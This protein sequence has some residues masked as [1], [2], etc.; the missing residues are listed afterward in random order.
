VAVVN[1]VNEQL[2]TSKKCPPTWQKA[3]LTAL[4]DGGNVRLACTAAQVGRTTVYERRAADAGFAAAWDV[5]LEA[6]A[7]LLEAEARRRAHDG[8]DEPVFGNLGAGRGSGEVGTV[9][10]YSDTL[11]IFLLKGARPEKYRERSDVKVSGEIA[12]V[13]AGFDPDNI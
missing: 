7:D 1:V 8:W 13:Y 12:K 11:L 2:R 5:A 3:F 9:R 4:Q 6:A 10:K